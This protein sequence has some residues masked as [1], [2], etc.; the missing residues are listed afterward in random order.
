MSTHLLA[1]PRSWH[2]SLCAL[3]RLRGRQAE[4][5]VCSPRCHYP[6]PLSPPPGVAF[7][8]DHLLNKP[9]AHKTQGAPPPPASLRKQHM[10]THRKRSFSLGPGSWVAPTIGGTEGG[11]P[12]E[13][14]KAFSSPSVRH[15]GIVLTPEQAGFVPFKKLLK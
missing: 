15:L 6:L 10:G 9:P 1:L 12:E 2:P 14:A 5:G 13:H 11:A 4:D 7:L 3:R 8:R